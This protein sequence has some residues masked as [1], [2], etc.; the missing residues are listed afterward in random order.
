ME[1]IQNPWKGFHCLRAIAARI[2]EQDYAAIM[3]LL[4]DSSEDDVRARLRPILWVNILKDNQ[5]IKIFRNFQGSQFTEI[6]RT[7]VGV[8]RRAKQRR[9]AARNRFEQQLRCVQLQP[10]MLRPTERQVR[11]VIGMVPDFVSFVDDPTNKRRV[12]LC[13]YSDYE[14]CGL[15]VCGFKNVQ[16]FRRPS[17]IRTVIKGNCD[18]M[19]AAC[20]LMI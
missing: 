19:L 18:L 14:K 16:D 1:P 5:I 8:V 9:R 10:D 2:V 6:C 20:T 15:Y 11:M 13:V 12:T 3:P 17:R 7:S 4:L